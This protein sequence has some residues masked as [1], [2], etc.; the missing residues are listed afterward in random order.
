M[1]L[2]GLKRNPPHGNIDQIELLSSELKT[3]YHKISDRFD[4][5]YTI[6]CFLFVIFPFR[7]FEYL[8][9]T[10]ISIMPPLKTSSLHIFIY[11]QINLEAHEKSI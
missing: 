1:F 8:I 5:V 6:D 7:F 9:L 10:Y 2:C 4:S 11:I 3:N